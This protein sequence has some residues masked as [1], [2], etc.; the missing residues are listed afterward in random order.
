MAAGLRVEWVEPNPII[1]ERLVVILDRAHTLRPP[2][3]G[4]DLVPWD[5]DAGIGS[6]HLTVV[7]WTN[8]L[9]V[10]PSPS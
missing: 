7:A 8:A 10:A 1:D 3:A 4:F 5:L 9:W 6:R 2:V